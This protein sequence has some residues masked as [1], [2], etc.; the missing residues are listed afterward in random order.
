MLTYLRYM[1]SD[2]AI[3]MYQSLF[4]TFFFISYFYFYVNVLGFVFLSYFSIIS[5]PR[6]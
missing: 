4:T 5:C 1:I 3:V 2:E 6:L